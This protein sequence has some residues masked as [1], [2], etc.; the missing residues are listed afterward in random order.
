[1]AIQ[2]MNRN[3]MSVHTYDKTITQKKNKEKNSID[4]SKVMNL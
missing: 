3:Q 2:C 1:M 4:R